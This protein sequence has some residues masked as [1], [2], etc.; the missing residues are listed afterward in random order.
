MGIAIAVLVATGTRD[1]GLTAYAAMS[2]MVPVGFV[3]SLS[4]RGG[5]RKAVLASAAAAATIAAAVAWYFHAAPDQ[6]PWL[7]IGSASALAAGVSVVNVA[8]TGRAPILR[9]CLRHHHQ[10]ALA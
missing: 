2:T 6:E 10:P 3:S 9:E 1:P 5:Y 4:S 7:V 8:R